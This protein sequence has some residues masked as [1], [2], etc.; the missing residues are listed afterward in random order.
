MKYPLTGVS[1]GT[2]TIVPPNKFGIFAVHDA[3]Q[4]TAEDHTKILDGPMAAAELGL[5]D[6]L[7]KR[8]E[9]D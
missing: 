5:L 8:A 6:E 9:S 3:D 1:R 4:F 2:S 7:S